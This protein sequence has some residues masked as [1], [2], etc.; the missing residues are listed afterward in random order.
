M[1]T[2]EAPKVGLQQGANEVLVI[3]FD[4]QRTQVDRLAKAMRT[5]ISVQALEGKAASWAFARWAPPS[6]GG[7]AWVA[8]N[9]KVPAATRG[10]GKA[11]LSTD[12]KAPLWFSTA[13]E[14][15]GKIDGP[16]ELLCSGLSRG[17]VFVNDELVG[18]YDTADG[19]EVVELPSERLAARNSITIFDLE[20]RAPA[21][22]KV[23]A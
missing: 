18:A 2:R 7:N 21:G 23:R 4:A 5:H 6:H 3:P 19:R 11:T 15:N 8:M 13:F 16:V 12:G 20:G 10:N 22:V 14:R 1:A 17:H 9:G